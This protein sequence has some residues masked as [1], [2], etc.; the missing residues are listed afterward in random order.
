M[1]PT[2]AGV[3]GVEYYAALDVE[4]TRTPAVPH[5]VYRRLPGHYRDEAFGRDGTWIPTDWFHER[6]YRATEDGVVVRIT[7][8]QAA[9]IIHRWRETGV[10]AKVDGVDISLLPSPHGPAES[11][12]PGAPEA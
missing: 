5:G 8:E 3:P 4:V 9:V 1:M 6:D 11:G 7:P 10:V 12:D 2:E